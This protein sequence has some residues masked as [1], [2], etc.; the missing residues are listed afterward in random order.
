M[1]SL[2]I[3]KLS[4]GAY[5]DFFSYDSGLIKALG[6]VNLKVKD[7]SINLQPCYLQANKTSD[8]ELIIYDLLVKIAAGGFLEK[9]SLSCGNNEMGEPFHIRFPSSF[10]SLHYLKIRPG[11][12]HPLEPYQIQN[13]MVVNLTSRQQNTKT[14]GKNQFVPGNNYPNVK[15]LIMDDLSVQSDCSF[16]F[17]N[18]ETLQI[19]ISEDCKNTSSFLSNAL[20]QFLNLKHLKLEFGIHDR[21]HEQVELWDWITGRIR[22]VMNSLTNPH[23]ILNSFNQAKPEEIN[24][25]TPALQPL[26]RKF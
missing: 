26:L 23:V 17:P 20:L 12:A 3:S 2:K 6:K 14:H 16:G 19:S 11:T 21:K 1:E 13:L 9:L 18:L 24:T 10:P 22:P 4:M 5:A 8:M 7:L 15:L 25:L